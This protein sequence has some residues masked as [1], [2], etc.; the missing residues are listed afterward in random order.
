MIDGLDH[1][2]NL[3]LNDQKNTLINIDK[4]IMRKQMRQNVISGKF[5][6]TDGSS[7]Y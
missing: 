6:Y 2:S 5:G 4:L 1:I 7:M 3:L